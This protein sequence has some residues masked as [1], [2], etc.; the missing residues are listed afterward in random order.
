MVLAWQNRTGGIV[1]DSVSNIMQARPA[2]LV[3]GPGYRDLVVRGHLR[4]N[5]DT[6]GISLVGTDLTP[7][8]RPTA[9]A[10]EME[11]NN[12][13]FSADSP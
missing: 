4:L 3:R 5:A 13:S 1:V 9:P 8:G 2:L 10:S 12:C 7:N 11:Q 6:E